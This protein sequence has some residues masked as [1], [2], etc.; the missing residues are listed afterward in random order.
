LA[1]LVDVGARLKAGR[2]QFAMGCSRPADRARVRLD[3][4]HARFAVWSDDERSSA[5]RPKSNWN[6]DSK[7]IWLGAVGDDTVAGHKP[8][9]NRL[10][11]CSPAGQAGEGPAAQEDVNPR[12]VNLDTRDQGSQF[13]AARR[14]T[15]FSHQSNDAC[16][17]QAIERL[18]RHATDGVIIL[19]IRCS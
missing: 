14:L 2:L 1:K 4:P 13:V 10:D 7:S 19:R 3:L 17:S 5:P 8:R 6:F 18:G 12:S 15:A 16:L 11:G 9:T